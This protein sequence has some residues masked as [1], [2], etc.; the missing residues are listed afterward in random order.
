M[1]CVVAFA[2]VVLLAQ[3]LGSTSAAFFRHHREVRSH[4]RFGNLVQRVR[5]KKDLSSSVTKNRPANPFAGILKRAKKDLSNSV[6]KSRPANPFAGILKRRER[7]FDG[8]FG[9][10]NGMLQEEERMLE[11]VENEIEQG[12]LQEVDSNSYE[13]DLGNGEKAKV[14]EEVLE[15]KDTGASIVI[16]TISAEGGGDLGLDLEDLELPDFAELGFNPEDLPDSPFDNKNCVHDD[17]CDGDMVCFGPVFDRVCG[18]PYGEG[19]PCFQDDMC[20]RDALCVMGKCKKGAV[21]GQEG[22]VCHVAADCQDGLCCGYMEGDEFI[23]IVT[24]VCRPFFQEGEPCGH[25][26]F[27]ALLM[28]SAG[29]CS[30]NTGLHCAQDEFAPRGH[31][32]CTADESQVPDIGIEPEDIPLPPIHHLAR[33][34][35]R[36][37]ENF[38]DISGV[39]EKFRQW[40]KVVVGMVDQAEGYEEECPETED[41][42]ENTEDNPKDPKDGPEKTDDNQDIA[43]ATEDEAEDDGFDEFLGEFRDLVNAEVFPSDDSDGADDSPENTEDIPENTDDNPNIADATEAKPEDDDFDEFL[44]EFRDLVNEEVFPSD[45]SDGADDSPEIT[46]DRPENTDDNPN[47]AD[48]TEAEPEDDDFD[49]F[50]GEF[51]DLVNEEVFPAGE[52]SEQ[53]DDTE[54]DFPDDTLKF[55]PFRG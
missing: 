26:G 9:L 3:L 40:V 22:C 38:N 42:P 24:P 31:H 2:A 27:L 32:V 12:N 21:Q 54:E 20:R 1:K 11:A 7:S 14:H 17:D 19:H 48:D 4:D 10:V 8:L 36:A 33:R 50:L 44:G 29:D 18:V 51:S 47:I 34:E 52:S 35:I 46:D 53:A 45:D 15:D 39:L 16:D 37:A 28:G 43:D 55:E 30:C 13:E 41:G 6:A 25:G 49:E 23:D 5:V